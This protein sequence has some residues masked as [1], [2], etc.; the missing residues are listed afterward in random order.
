MELTVN[1]TPEL[2]LEQALKEKGIENIS[3][4]TKLIVAGTLG[5][6]DFRY[7]GKKMDKT[8]Q[9]LDMGD[10][11]LEKNTIRAK[12]FYQPCELTAIT[13]PDSV[14]SINLKAFNDCPNLHAITIRPNSKHP[15]ALSDNGVLFNKDKTKLL[16]CPL[17]RKGDYIIPDSVVRIGES[18]FEFRSGLTSITIP[19]SVKDIDRVAFRYCSGLTSIT[20][21]ESV[22]YIGDSVLYSCSGLLSIHVHTDN[23]NYASVDGVL[24]NKDKTKLLAFPGGLKKLIMLSPTQL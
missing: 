24:F 22:I 16:Y 21:P 12:T 5:K 1:L 23:P 14:D 19:N 11:V 3:D 17:G 20:I 2:R 13:I 7:M 9:E 18:A 6:D 8:L 4:V 10:A 15:R